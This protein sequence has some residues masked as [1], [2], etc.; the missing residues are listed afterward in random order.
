MRKSW[1]SLEVSKHLASSNKVCASRLATSK[2]VCENRR[3]LDTYL[4][5]L[6]IAVGHACV[7][8]SGLGPLRRHHPHLAALHR[9]DVSV[10]VALSDPFQTTARLPWQCRV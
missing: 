5:I 10:G 7:L 3:L 2:V 4:I 9:F 1:Q 6:H 8:G